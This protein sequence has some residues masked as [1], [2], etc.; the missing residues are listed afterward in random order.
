MKVNTFEVNLNKIG[1]L[2]NKIKWDSQKFCGLFKQ[3][4]KTGFC[5]S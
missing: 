4:I 2:N 1:I 3:I 5:G